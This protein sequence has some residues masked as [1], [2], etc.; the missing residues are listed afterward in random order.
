M[1]LIAHVI[2]SVSDP[3][4]MF[5]DGGCSEIS[6]H[7]TAF[8]DH[9]FFGGTNDVEFFRIDLCEE[10]GSPVPGDVIVI[11]TAAGISQE[12]SIAVCEPMLLG[13][14][15]AE[16]ETVIE[17]PGFDGSEMETIIADGDVAFEVIA[18]GEVEPARVFD[19]GGFADTSFDGNGDFVTVGF[20][21]H[22]FA[23]EATPHD[24]GRVIGMR[25]VIE[26]HGD[27]ERAVIVDMPL[28]ATGGNEVEFSVGIRGFEI[29]PF[30]PTIG[31]WVVDRIGAL[32]GTGFGDK[33]FACFAVNQ[34]NADG[35]E[36]ARGGMPSGGDV[37]NSDVGVIGAGSPIEFRG[38]NRRGPGFSEVIGAH[39]G[40]A[41]IM[42]GNAE[43]LLQSDDESRSAVFAL[44]GDG[45]DAWMKPAEF[46]AE[47]L[48]N[49]VEFYIE[50]DLLRLSI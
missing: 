34:F 22:G 50:G 1:G 19:E 20:V 45:G 43:V 18:E 39:E 42:I 26:V 10:Y 13:V 29:F 33:L 17:G 27:Q 48:M 5:V 7:G 4:F 49:D 14:V 38:E 2:F 41:G 36:F 25:R 30:G 37:G 31:F 24:G 32:M 3:G 15:T 6:E 40:D 23:I 21:N 12:E 44:S 28:N 11:G 8:G 9:G 35:D 46:G 16:I 47:F